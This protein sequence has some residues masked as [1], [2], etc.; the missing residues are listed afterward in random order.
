MKQISDRD[1][2]IN[3]KYLE[4][5]Y[6]RDERFSFRHHR[7]LEDTS[8]MVEFLRGF[9]QLLQLLERLIRWRGAVL[10]R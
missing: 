4:S 7:I 10:R 9:D 3:Q 6:L 5:T 2:L 8:G 1:M